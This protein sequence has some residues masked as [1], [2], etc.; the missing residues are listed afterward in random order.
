MTL[1]LDTDDLPEYWS[2]LM[3]AVAVTSEL[4]S[5]SCKI[6]QNSDMTKLNVTDR[7]RVSEVTTVTLLL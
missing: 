5:G 2:D 7:H 4:H 3:S 1:I 6:R